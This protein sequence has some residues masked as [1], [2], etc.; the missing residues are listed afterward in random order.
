MKNYIESSDWSYSMLK[1]TFKTF[2]FIAL[3]MSIFMSIY[4]V[5]KT[6][7]LLFYL[8]SILFV[9]ISYFLIKNYKKIIRNFYMVKM[10]QEHILLKKNIKIE[11]TI[12][13]KEVTKIKRIPFI[14]PPVYSLKTRQFDD[15]IYFPSGSSQ[16]YFS[17]SI[18]GFQFIYDTSEMGKH[19]RKM[20]KVYN[21][22]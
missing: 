4:A 8:F 5:F 17:I 6:N 11:N 18:G 7:R 20:K 19:I 14:T 10:N 9:T 15:P 1:F 2:A 21:I 13:W 3:P 12:E 22:R 16:N